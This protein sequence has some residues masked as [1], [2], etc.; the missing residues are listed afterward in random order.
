[1]NDQEVKRMYEY[2]YKKHIKKHIRK[3]E[4]EELEQI[5][6]IHSKVSQNKYSGLNRPQEYLRDRSITS[7]QSYLLFF[8]EAR[9]LEGLK[10]I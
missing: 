1:M 9:Q 10:R 6:S 5:R 8:Q 4:F 3:V 7:K 2:E